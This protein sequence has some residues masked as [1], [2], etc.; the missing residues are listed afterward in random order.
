MCRS[1]RR[2]GSHAGRSGLLG[3]TAGEDLGLKDLPDRSDIAEVLSGGAAS[4]PQPQDAEGILQISSRPMHVP[5]RS[6]S[7]CRDWPISGC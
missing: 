7:G 5:G 4:Y 6:I 1:G 2:R 3:T